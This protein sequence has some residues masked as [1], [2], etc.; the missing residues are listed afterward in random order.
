M[1]AIFRLPDLDEYVH[2]GADRADFYQVRPGLLRRQS[3]ELLTG[4]IN[5]VPV[6][7]IFHPVLRRIRII[8]VRGDQQS[9][10]GQQIIKNI[11][12]PLA[13]LVQ[14]I[15][16]EPGAIDQI[17]F[18]GRAE[19][20]GC[21]LDELIDRFLHQLDLCGA[22]VTPLDLT[23]HLGGVSQRFVIEVK[24]RKIRVPADIVIGKEIL[25]LLCRTAAQIEN[26]R[27]SSALPRPEGL[28]PEQ[29]YQIDQ[30]VSMRFNRRG[31][32]E[33]AVQNLGED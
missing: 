7:R 5:Q 17:V 2:S 16:K 3:R 19:W 28:S 12:Q 13:N 33:D 26:A 27:R 8:H 30:P 4:S 14:Q 24:E 11:H 9:P 25:N 23:Q 20:F 10:W 1:S 18:R 29:L 21:F 15:I 6:Q 32:E 22:V 31:A